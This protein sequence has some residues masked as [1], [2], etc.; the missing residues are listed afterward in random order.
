MIVISCVPSI[1]TRHV[2]ESVGDLLQPRDPPGLAQL[3]LVVARRIL[4]QQRN[5]PLRD[6][7]PPVDPGE[8]LCDHGANAEL[9]RGQRGVLAA[10][11]LAV[12]VAGD[13]EPSAPLLR[14]PRELRVSVLERE[15]RDRGHVRA[16]RHHGRA[17][18][19]QVTGG[20]VV[21]RDDQDTELERVGQLL[22]LG[23]RLDVR[24]ARDLDRPGLVG[25]N[26][27]E[28]VRLDDR[29]SR[30]RA[31]G[32]VGRGQLSRVG[33]LAL[34]HRRGRNRRGAQVDAVV[35]RSAASREVPVERAQRV[36]ARGRRL[37][38]A[39]ARPAGRLEHP[40]ARR[41]Q[42]DIGARLRDLVEDL[43]R[44]RRRGRRDQLL[45]E[46]VAAEHRAADGHVLVGR[47]DRR[48]DADLRQ[49]RAHELVDRDDV[50]RAR[51]LRDERDER[52]EVD[53]LD[54]VEVVR[55]VAGG[56][57]REVL[58]ALLLVEP[59]LR[60]VVGREH[61]AG[62][63]EL[64]DHVR[65]RP[66]LGVRKRRHA[67]AGELE[68]RAPPTAHAAPAQQLEDHVLR[69]DPGPL[70]LVLEE[71]ADDLRARQLE[72]MPGH[73][74][75]DV[76]AARRRSRSSRP[77]PTAS[78]GCPRRRASCPESQTA[79]SGCSGRSRSPA[80]RTTRR[81]SQP[82]PAGTGGRPGS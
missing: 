52:R 64:R 74:D 9:R 55:R 70:Q 5:D 34:Q 12:V 33:D 48:A 67:R 73:A 1:S 30:G 16:V 78:C 42:L 76:Q 11:S 77:S 25:R 29:R 44:A 45:G 35:G 14:A 31:R 75:G 59:A 71:D 81:T 65:D 28:D 6:Q 3:G 17:V 58:R 46:P 20:D 4:E 60:L 37:A 27:L 61:G 80:E 57:L 51:R 50:A 63:A 79:R 66:A 22:L 8:A 62:R 36:R 21:G 69:L 2:V 19:G 26:R 82:W 38:H 72:G 15:L 47:V 43:P 23:R 56:Q 13:D 54:L 24:A 49:R 68:D 39:D 7:V 41:Q 32:Q 18:R 10:R 53:L 40:D